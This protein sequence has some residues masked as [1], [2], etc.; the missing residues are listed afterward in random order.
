VTNRNDSGAASSSG[1]M[2]PR[3]R[4]RRKAYVVA[5]GLTVM[6]W[7]AAAADHIM[8]DRWGKVLRTAQKP[9]LVNGLRFRLGVFLDEPVEPSPLVQRYLVLIS[10]DECQ[11]SQAELPRWLKLLDRVR[12][13][14][15][16]EVLL[17]SSSGSRIQ[18]ALQSVLDG[19]GTA[20]RRLVVLNRA[21]FGANTGV[22]WTPETLALDGSMRIRIA[23]ERVTPT[24]EDQVVRW[25]AA[26]PDVEHGG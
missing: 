21:G 16:D 14:D 20:Y 3:S 1:T 13:D 6:Y 12:F 24:V 23:S 9:L 8:Y 26:G 4:M 2:Q 11:Y 15:R 17:V 18:D 5:I 10:A 19:R 25:W 22:S 7:S